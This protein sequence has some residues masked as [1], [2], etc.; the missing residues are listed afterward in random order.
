M[1][2][3]SISLCCLPYFSCFY[4]LT[5]IPRECHFFLP[6]PRCFCG[7]ADTPQQSVSETLQCQQLLPAITCSRCFYT[8]ADTTLQVE[9]RY[10]RV[11]APTACHTV[12]RFL[13]NPAISNANPCVSRQMLLPAILCS[14]CFY[15]QLVCLASM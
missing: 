4:S 13:Y 1:P 7:S 15:I 10:C 3:Q 8:L 2:L 11:T 6:Y 5:D 9:E 14:T 12:L